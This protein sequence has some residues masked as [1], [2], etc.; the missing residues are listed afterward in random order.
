V[1]QVAIFAKGQPSAN[2]VLEA[3]KQRIDSPEGRRRYSQH[4]GTVEPVFWQHPAQ[5]AVEP[6]HAAREQEGGQ[7][8]E[9]VLAGA[10]HR[11][12]G[13]VRPEEIACGMRVLFGAKM[14][15][16]GMIRRSINRERHQ[17]GPAPWR[18]RKPNPCASLRLDLGFLHSLVKFQYERVPLPF[19][20]C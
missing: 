9:A 19:L 5:Q 10:Q 2:D 13:W 14:R 1:R 11:E 8:V 3:M 18:S 6:F 16:R 4:I 20:Q 12:T 15:A 17:E 7:A